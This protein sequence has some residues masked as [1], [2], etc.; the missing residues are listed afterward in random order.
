M[1]V[2]S[3]PEDYSRIKDGSLEQGTCPAKVQ[4]LFEKMLGEEL[5]MLRH[6]VLIDV[7]T[8]SRS[9][10]ILIQDE[11]VSNISDSFHQARLIIG[12]I[13]WFLILAVSPVDFV[14]KAFCIV[15]SVVSL[16]INGV[17]YVSTKIRPT[18]SILRCVRTVNFV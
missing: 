6:K 5:S 1:C 3:A 14:S 7:S 16:L 15:C 11:R 18:N 17:R 2:D 9:F 4:R 12:M 8:V 13:G 10:E